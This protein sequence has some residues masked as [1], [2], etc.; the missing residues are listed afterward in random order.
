V[1]VEPGQDDARYRLSETVRQ[2]AA[3]R[4]TEAGEAE[5]TRDRHRDYFVA[6]GRRQG[7]A[8]TRPTAWFRRLTVD[9]DNFR[10]ALEWCFASGDTLSA[11]RLAGAMAEFW[12][13]E[14]RLDEGCAWVER[15][16]AESPTAPDRTR[17]RVLLGLAFLRQE[18]G[19]LERAL[20][21]LDAA[22][23][24]FQRASD[25][26]GGLS[27]I[28]VK[29]ALLLQQGDVEG[30]ERICREGV[31]IG[32]ALGIHVGSGWCRFS[33]GWVALANGDRDAALTEFEASL[34]A[35]KAAGAPD[36][37]TA[38]VLAA[39]APLVAA[40]GDG[41][42]AE[43]LIAQAL[44]HA[45][46]LGRVHLVMVLTRAAEIGV[47]TGDLD[48]A[49]GALVESLALLRDIAGRGYVADSLELAALVVLERGDP[50]AAARL[51]GAADGVRRALGESGQ[52]RLVRAEVEVG[53]GKTADMLGQDG[54]AKEYGRGRAVTPEAATA[55]ALEQ[56]A[57]RIEMEDA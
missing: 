20:D 22:A 53:R 43:A 38:H 13:F 29:G 54:F 40:K 1:P 47:V 9:H 21:L 44:L 6:A 2:Y 18:Q 57:G 32:E 37:R 30:A 33:L 45:R 10:A 5:I 27:V 46:E 7:N 19:D 14:G 51:F 35:M 49:A 41:P 55:Y 39:L 25:P 52:V 23:A 15:A 34:A 36:D 11:L 48:R 17:G 42:R 3:D 31:G 4:L 28:V 56:I 24:L 50:G 12:T 8:L 26:E 16:L